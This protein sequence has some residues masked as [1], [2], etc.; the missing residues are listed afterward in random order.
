MFYDIPRLRFL[1][2][3]SFSAVELTSKN[4]QPFYH[5]FFFFFTF[6][7]SSAGSFRTIK[8]ISIREM[9][10]DIKYYMTYEGSTTHPGCWETAVW[11]VLNKPIYITRR[12]VSITC[13]IRVTQTVV[14]EKRRDTINC[15]AVPRTRDGGDERF[16]LC[17][18]GKH[19]LCVRLSP[20]GPPLKQTF[21]D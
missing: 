7:S 2:R 14:M 5:F 11:I 18:E 6:F 15:D 9:L 12:E 3:T 10:P 8:D 17:C 13:F 1:M 21:S 16:T 19:A 20:M 4:L